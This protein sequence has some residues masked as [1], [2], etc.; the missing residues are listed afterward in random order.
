MA[1]VNLQ[2]IL[3]ADQPELDVD[4]VIHLLET[5]NWDESVSSHFRNLT[6]LGCCF[7]F[8]CLDSCSRETQRPLKATA[9]YSRL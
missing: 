2:A 9:D 1:I 6:F 4:A 5:N 3:S 8:L 7:S